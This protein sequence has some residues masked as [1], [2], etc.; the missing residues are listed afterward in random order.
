MLIRALDHSNTRLVEP[1][2]HALD[3]FLQGEW[4]LVQAGVRANADE[5]RD[6]RPTKRYRI[7]TA[8]LRIPPTA[9]R[10]MMFGAAVLGVEQDVCVNEDHE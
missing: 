2:L 4:T 9:R 6:Y 5:R 7:R 8:Q 10:F 3:G 1:T